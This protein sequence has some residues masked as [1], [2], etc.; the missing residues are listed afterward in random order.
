MP[1]CRLTIA[2][3]PTTWSAVGGVLASLSAVVLASLWRKAPHPFFHDE[4]MV[5]A[6][7]PS[8]E[9]RRAV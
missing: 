4:R 6:A 8:P 7:V 1:G 5:W 3:S 9:R 2:P